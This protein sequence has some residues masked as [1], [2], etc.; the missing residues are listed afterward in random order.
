ME[1]KFSAVCKHQH[2]TGFLFVSR[3]ARAHNAHTLMPVRSFNETKAQSHSVARY[4]TTGISVESV[5]ATAAAFCS[6]Y[7]FL[8]CVGSFPF[9]FHSRCIWPH[10]CV[11]GCRKKCT[12]LHCL[13]CGFTGHC[14][15]KKKKKEECLHQS[16]RGG[17]FFFLYWCIGYYWLT[18][19]IYVK[20]WST[21]IASFVTLCS[22]LWVSYLG[23]QKVAAMT[24][25][26]SH[27]QLPL[28]GPLYNIGH[29]IFLWLKSTAPALFKQQLVHS[30]IVFTVQPVVVFVLQV[31]FFF[32]LLVHHNLQC[33]IIHLV[34]KM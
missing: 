2:S 4:S 19:H 7:L 6:F 21:M 8:V 30:C 18:H 24:I 31:S 22:W 33:H 17:D 3:R 12:K 5:I 13:L 25:G 15:I 28:I 27:N 1:R 23:I 32:F 16:R 9:F 26:C 34:D 11:C 10:L 29:L 14:T 20:Q